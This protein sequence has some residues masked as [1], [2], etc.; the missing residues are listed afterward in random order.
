[1]NLLQVTNQG[2]IYL[3]C[4]NDGRTYELIRSGT[5]KDLEPTFQHL[6]SGVP[7]GKASSIVP[8]GVAAVLSGS[9]IVQFKEIKKAIKANILIN[10]TF[11]TKFS[12]KGCF[13]KLRDVSDAEFE[14]VVRLGDQFAAVIFKGDSPAASKPMGYGELLSYLQLFKYKQ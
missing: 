1:M 2:T 5:N 3:V 13:L 8:D 9:E 12:A 11:Y 10:G 4:Y 7:F 6:A 14:I